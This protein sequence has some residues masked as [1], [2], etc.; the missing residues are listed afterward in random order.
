[1]PKDNDRVSEKLHEAMELAYKL[2]G[3]D[4][5]KRS[6]VPYLA[7]LLSVCAMVQMDGGD[8][9]E[10][11]AALLHDAL[12]DKA[13]QISGDDIERQFGAKVLQ[14]VRISSDTQEDYKGGPKRPWLE[15]K[16]AYLEHVSTVNDPALLRVTVADKVDNARAILADH[17]RIGD[18]LWGHFNAGKEKQLWYYRE[19]VKAYEKAR[20]NSPLLEE[21][22][23]LVEDLTQRVNAN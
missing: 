19:C 1:M 22:R 7:H 10:A 21:L 3:W 5:R 15:R 12:E 9:E 20:F 6:P 8:E 18:E 2:H 13:D 11:I 4:S 16:T 17:Q 23:R 14:I